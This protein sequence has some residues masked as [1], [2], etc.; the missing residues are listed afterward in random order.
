MEIRWRLFQYHFDF[1]NSMGCVG[2]VQLRSQLLYKAEHSFH[3]CVGA[4][5]IKLAETL[6]SKYQSFLPEYSFQVNLFN[7]MK[8]I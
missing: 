5:L 3:Q 8:E 1:Y 6:S 4:S 2:E 7:S